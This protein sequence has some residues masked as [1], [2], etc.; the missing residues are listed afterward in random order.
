MLRKQA[1]ESGQSGYHSGKT[2]GNSSHSLHDGE[3]VS[4]RES[5]EVLREAS[6]VEQD[7]AYAELCRATDA[8]ALRFGDKASAVKNSANNAKQ[9]SSENDETFWSICA[10]K[11]LCL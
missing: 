7:Q 2:T 9:D 5:N 11:S 10:S 4:T 8:L 1:I 3:T 6:D